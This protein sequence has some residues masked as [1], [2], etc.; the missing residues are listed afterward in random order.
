MKQSN[1]KVW[2]AGEAL[3]DLLPED[4]GQR[5]V[6]GGGPA[7]TAKALANLGNKVSFIGGISNDKYGHLIEAELDSYGVDLSFAQRSELQTAIA[8]VSFDKSNSAIYRF[9]LNDTATFD[10]AEWLPN[11]VPDLLHIGSLA[12]IVEPGASHLF[13]WAI[14]IARDGGKIF[15]DPNVRSSVL[16]DSGLYRKY[17]EKWA[18]ISNVVK[19]SEDDLSFLNLSVKEILD[20]GVDLLVVTKGSAGMIGYQDGSSITVSGIRVPVVDT[21][22]AGDT[23][24]AVLI[25]S[26]IQS[27]PIKQAN[28]EEVLSQAAR[29]AA[30]TCS[31]AGAKPPTLEELQSFST[32]Q[33]LTL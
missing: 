18:K 3:I 13:E 1:T 31:R 26:F 14:R 23:V 30:I 8:E 33:H 32:N 10:F 28:L 24:S 29:A 4:G 7:N 15:F 27:G 6:V 25:T 11:F 22:G 2:V 21:V 20:F 16:D 17:F 9:T 12:T 5:P 19:A